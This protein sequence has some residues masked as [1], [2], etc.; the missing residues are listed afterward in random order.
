MRTIAEIFK[1]MSPRQRYA[2][3]YY[4]RRDKRL[5]RY[6]FHEAVREVQL[7]GVGHMLSRAFNKGYTVEQLII[8]ESANEALELI[9]NYID[10]CLDVMDETAYDATGFLNNVPNTEL[11]RYVNYHCALNCYHLLSD[12]KDTL[13]PNIIL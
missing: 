11:D 10:A 8:L 4:C 13:A 2:V 6:S 3:R 5:G 1:E 7:Y 9:E 12:I